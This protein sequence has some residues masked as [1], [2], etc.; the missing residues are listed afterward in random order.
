MNTSSAPKKNNAVWRFKNS[1]K[2]LDLR[3]IALCDPTGKL[4]N[5]ADLIVYLPPV[6]YQFR[7]SK[8]THYE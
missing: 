3:L 6:V 7:Q 5:D 1:N 8:M 2:D 4:V